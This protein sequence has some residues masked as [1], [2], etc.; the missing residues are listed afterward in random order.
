MNKNRIIL[1]SAAIVAV[2]ALLFYLEDPSPKLRSEARQFTRQYEGK[3]GFAII[4][5]P[6]FLMNE[7][8]PESDSAGIKKENFKSFRVMIFHQD[9]A[10]AHSCRETEQAMRSFLDSMEFRQIV[11]KEAD[12]N[13][14]MRIFEKEKTGSWKENVTLFSSDSTLFMF[15]YISNLKQD[16]VETFSR[17]LGHREFL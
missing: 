7:V 4:K 5:M 9:D 8:L 14:M 13:R 3:K 6:D 12:A 2:F 15:N 10:T 16:E 17:Q 11:E 1:Y